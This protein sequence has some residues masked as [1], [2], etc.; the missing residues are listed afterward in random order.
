MSGCCAVGFTQSV[1][2]MLI[3]LLQQSNTV[4]LTEYWSKWCSIFFIQVF[5][6]LAMSPNMYVIL[7]SSILGKII[8]LNLFQG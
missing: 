6:G 7:Y 5:I 8:T 3:V 2:L 1:C 4:A